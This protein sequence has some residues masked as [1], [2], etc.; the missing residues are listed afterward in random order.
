[1]NLVTFL[2]KAKRYIQT[3]TPN[4]VP[5]W[6]K[7]QPFDISP[8]AQGE[9]NMNYLVQQANQPAWVFRVNVGSQIHRDDQ[10]EYEFNALALLQGSRRTPI[11]FFVDDSRE[12]ID[13]GVLGMSY[14]PGKMMCYET[15]GLGAAR[16]FADI[17]SFTHRL[18]DTHL[19]IEQLPLTM[20]YQEC[21]QLLPAY[22]ESPLADKTIRSFLQE[23][24]DWANEA[25]EKEAYFI[26]D[27]WNCIINTEVNSSNFIYNA[28]SNSLHLVDW[29]KPL[30]GDP[31]QDLSHF[32][33]PTTTLWKTE[34][35]M[36][37][38]TK[39]AF[40]ESY[41]EGLSDHHLKDTIHDRIRLRDPFN[42]LRGISWSAWAWVAYQTG[43]A[44]IKNEDTYR[45]LCAYM[46][47][48]FIRSLFESYMKGNGHVG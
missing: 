48:T 14:L 18:E 40:V 13:M 11:P 2:P 16:L 15:Q 39:K 27:P 21:S 12:K 1:M 31:S 29:E 25:R 45:K 35:R 4:M 44:A 41:C 37:N 32:C 47:I 23:V 28:E 43:D 6:Q 34:Y 24:L 19:I 38:S 9:Y 8:L 36:A 3:V 7:D 5:C 10:I 26:S 46:N 30:W 20:T 17:H 33:V 42:C 22:F